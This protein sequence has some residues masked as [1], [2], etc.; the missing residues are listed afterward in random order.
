MQN[1]KNIDNLTKNEGETAQPRL[2]D[3]DT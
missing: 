1:I 2:N 3:L